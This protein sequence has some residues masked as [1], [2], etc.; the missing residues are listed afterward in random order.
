MRKVI[1][2]RLDGLAGAPHRL[3]HVIGQSPFENQPGFHATEDRWG[4]LDESEDELLGV[5]DVWLSPGTIY[6]EIALSVRTSRT[7]DR[8]TATRGLLEL[9]AANAKQ[10]G[11]T[12]VLTYLAQED[13]H[14]KQVL[15]NLGFKQVSGYRR[16]RTRPH[17]P[18]EAIRFLPG[19]ALSTYADVQD[20]SFLA[21]ALERSYNGQWGHKYPNSALLEVMLKAFPH[22]AIFLLLDESSRPAGICKS[23]QLPGETNEES[24]TGYIDAPGV[25]APHRT[26][27]NYAALVKAAT[28]WHIEKGSK[29]ILLESWGDP[30]ELPA[31]YS[32]LGFELEEETPGY[33]LEL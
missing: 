5:A 8:A 3:S 4:A 14:L 16:M 33:V 19:L 21:K 7:G 6:A 30:P 25:V 10:K 9:S 27:D 18:A 13:Q 15:E 28:D 20:Q 29:E 24:P 26:L 32:E 1:V 2:K 17:S 23:T 22:D 31:A 12:A 11:A